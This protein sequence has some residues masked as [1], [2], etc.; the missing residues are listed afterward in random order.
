MSSIN[1]QEIEITADL[2]QSLKISKVFTDHHKEINSLDFFHD[3]TLIVTCD[4]TTLNVYDV[5]TGKYSFA[6]IGK[7]ERSIIRL[8]KLKLLNLL[9]IIQQSYVPLKK[10]L[11]KFYIGLC[12][13]TKSLGSF[14][15]IPIPSPAQ[16]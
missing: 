10:N 14:L 8:K 1:E 12:M 7:Q 4:D 13:K 2:L 5:L 3:G 15:D 16:K 6:Y 9:I 11:M